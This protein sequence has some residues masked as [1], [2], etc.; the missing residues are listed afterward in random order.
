M[1]RHLQG[2][3]DTTDAEW[4]GPTVGWWLSPSD[5]ADLAPPW[6]GTDTATGAGERGD[7]LTVILVRHLR[8]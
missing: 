7:A 6:V 3:G 1:P 2:E 4:I 8:I 5:T